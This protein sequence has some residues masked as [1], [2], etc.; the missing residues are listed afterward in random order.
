LLLTHPLPA[1]SGLLLQA[2]EAAGVRA[3][4]AQGF[5]P[6]DIGDN[7]YDGSQRSLDQNQAVMSLWCVV[8]APLVA[9]CAPPPPPPHHSG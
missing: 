3:V 9:R 5:L 8:S 4:G 7:Y 1:G 6:L 2:A